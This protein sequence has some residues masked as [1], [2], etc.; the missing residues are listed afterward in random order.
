MCLKLMPG[1]FAQLRTTLEATGNIS[2][3]GQERYQLLCAA[4]FARSL[5]RRKGACAGS[6]VWRQSLAVDAEREARRRLHTQ[7]GWLG[8][9]IMGVSSEKWILLANS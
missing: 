1:F 2:H 5:L 7:L 3:E 4:L 9:I 6:H 8:V